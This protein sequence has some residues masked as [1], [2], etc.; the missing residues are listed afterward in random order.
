MLL[1]SI[2]S[3]FTVLRRFVSE[4]INICIIFRAI[5][6]YIKIHGPPAHWAPILFLHRINAIE[7]KITF[8]GIKTFMVFI[9]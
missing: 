6:G 3:F 4:Q 5:L 7:V 1:I 9:S 2:P 8:D